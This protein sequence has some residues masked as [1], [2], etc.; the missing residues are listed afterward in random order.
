MR[1]DVAQ[2]EIIVALCIIEEQYASYQSEKHVDENYAPCAYNQ[3]GI[4]MIVLVRRCLEEFAQLMRKEPA[5]GMYDKGREHKAEYKHTADDMVLSKVVRNRFCLDSVCSDFKFG[6]QEY[7][8]L[9]IS[10]MV[11]L[12]QIVNGV[13]HPTLQSWYFQS[14]GALAP[15]YL[16]GWE[17]RLYDGVYL[18]WRTTLHLPY[19][20][21]HPILGSI[22]SGTG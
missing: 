21:S 1:W 6:M 9:K 2:E 17:V 7:V 16:S 22:L 12:G 20:T 8:V 3:I 10:K 5:S 19:D 4:Y 18:A 13:C 15:L 14:V 11:A